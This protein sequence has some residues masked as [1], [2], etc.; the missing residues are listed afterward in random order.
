MFD[1]F[2]TPQN[3]QSIALPALPKIYLKAFISRK[4]GLT[5]NE[6]FPKI[7]KYTE[8]VISDE[9]SKAYH[10]ICQTD[11][12]VNLITMPQVLIV[13][14]HFH[15]LS[16]PLSKM[17][18]FG[19]I[20]ARNEIFSRKPLASNQKL[21]VLAWTGESKWNDK[22]MYLDLWSAIDP[23][24]VGIDWSSLSA[25]QI[26]EKI[27]QAAWMCRMTV[28]KMKGK[29]KE[30][31]GKEVKKTVEPKS[32]DILPINHLIKWVLSADLGRKYASVSGDYNPIHLF[33]W[34]SRF[35]GF[36]EPII[37]G[38]WSLAR[39]LGELEKTN[40]ASQN[41][42]PVY[43]PSFLEVK[44]KRPI[45]IPTEVFL[46]MEEKLEK[47]QKDFTIYLSSSKVALDGS[48]IKQSL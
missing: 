24:F 36:K 16:D 13:P 27:S 8:I 4:A 10:D 44:F 20:H 7:S 30:T 40:F 34:T 41:P 21:G 11:V 15:I 9:F 31:E 32:G 45:S 18:I 46:K 5:E 38:M 19:L 29:A 12:K 28:F 37:H 22:G 6:N 2:P 3:I 39:A 33:P 23:S 1:H 42:D 14:L 43:K 17:P 26:Q 47:N 25:E 48:L 35:F